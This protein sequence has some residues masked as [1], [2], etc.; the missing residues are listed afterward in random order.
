MPYHYQSYLR[1][2]ML[3]TIEHQKLPTNNFEVQRILPFLCI[4]LR[5]TGI[6]IENN[7]LMIVFTINN[8]INVLRL[9]SE[10]VKAACPTCDDVR[11]PEGQECQMVKDLPACVPRIPGGCEEDK[12]G[13]GICSLFKRR[14]YAVIRQI[15]KIELTS[16]F[17]NFTPLLQYRWVCGRRPQL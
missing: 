16:K 8:W 7:T 13:K 3:T 11:C 12:C 5:Q 4:Q 6:K 9:S 14:I 10:Y 15:V 17:L 1:I 2:M